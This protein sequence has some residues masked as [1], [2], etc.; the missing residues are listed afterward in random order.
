MP[1][2]FPT[3]H[4]PPRASTADTWYHAS[5]PRP[6][7]PLAPPE[8][9]LDCDVAI[10]GAGF[11]GVS[12]ALDLA[13]SGRDVRVFEAGLLGAG[14]SGRNGGL[15]CSGWR[16]DQSWLEQRL[17]ATAAD[18][19][20]T[21]AEEAKSALTA[22][23]AR[24]VIAADYEAGLVHAAHTPRQ[25]Q[26]LDADAA[27]LRARYGYR[28]LERM[29]PAACVQALGAQLP[30]G[31]WRDDG[32]GRLHPLKLLHGLAGAARAAGAVLHEG[33]A[34][35]HLDDGP[36]LRLRSG[37]RVRARHVLLCGDGY[38]DGLSPMVERRVMPIG[39]FVVATEPLDPAL[40][41]MPGAVGAMDTRFVVNYFQRTADHRLVFG[42]G[43]K[44][45]P[46]WP[47]DIGG[48]VRRNLLKLFPQL[49]GVRITHAWGGA[50]GITATRLPFV[51]EVAPRV[52]SASGYS[53]QG[54]ALAPLFGQILAE[55]VQG[56]NDRLRLVASLPAPA[57]PGGRWLRWP[58][59]AG[60]MSWF[61][62][63][64][65]LG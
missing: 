43:E 24:H 26:A 15:V 23:M 49:E 20:W 8:R 47:D 10:V 34:V 32:A 28:K 59:L 35:S 31:G 64:D 54:V 62:L 42:G 13:L 12:A 33:T 7:A 51:A 11:T 5:A 14:A 61:A 29:D 45:T 19:L 63:R 18:A 17:G 44:Y 36:M 41:V 4:A 40:G 3:R 2:D 65:R 21:L 1:V 38:L 57:F 60:A 9:D 52:W 6:F 48:F 16:H 39:S 37:V 25:M 30:H 58:L 22:R 46:A 53:G 50:L 55:A 56:Q 27:H